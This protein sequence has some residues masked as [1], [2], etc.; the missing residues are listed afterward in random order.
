M[1][2]WDI[3]DFGHFRM[4]FFLNFVFPGLFGHN[5]GPLKKKKKWKYFF[6]R[7]G[8]STSI[9]AIDLAVQHICGDQGAEGYFLKPLLRIKAFWLCVNQILF[10]LTARKHCTSDASLYLDQL[11]YLFGIFVF[12]RSLVAFFCPLSS[13]SLSMAQIT[14]KSCWTK[15]RNVQNVGCVPKQ[16]ERIRNHFSRD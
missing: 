1:C 2:S 13:I 12:L 9:R 5:W 7:L 4:T 11:L 15:S 8:K 6:C 10:D 16:S 3:L 14:W